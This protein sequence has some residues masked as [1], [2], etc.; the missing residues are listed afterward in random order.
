MP[1]S[2]QSLDIAQQ[3]VARNFNVPPKYTRYLEKG[4]IPVLW[5]SIEKLFMHHY[6]Q[7]LDQD[8]FNNQ[9]DYGICQIVEEYGKFKE[10]VAPIL[11]AK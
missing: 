6:K 1:D 10:C 11:N 3:E 5:K 2:Y 7:N 9:M 8:E 4:D